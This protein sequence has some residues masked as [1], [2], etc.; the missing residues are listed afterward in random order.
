VRAA[1]FRVPSARLNGSLDVV[2]AVSELGREPIVSTAEQAQILGLRAAALARGM[3]VVEFQPSP[4]PAAA[5]LCVDPTAAESITLE[6]RTS[7][8]ARDPR[9]WRR[10]ERGDGGRC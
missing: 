10:G 8:R 9:A 6:H 3:V 1:S 7:S 5:A 4:A 2:T